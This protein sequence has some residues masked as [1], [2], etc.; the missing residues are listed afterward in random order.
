[1]R[2]ESVAKFQRV[3]SHM[4]GDKPLSL[5]QALSKEGMASATYYKVL[6]FEKKSAK[7]KVKT[8]SKFIDLAPANSLTSPRVVA[9]A[10]V[11]V[12]QLSEVLKAGVR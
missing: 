10:F 5:D 6:K 7:K 9:I 12:D 8:K 11:S 4:T 1:M 3:R 2:E